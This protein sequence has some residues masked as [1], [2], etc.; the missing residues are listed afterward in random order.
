MS[1]EVLIFGSFVLGWAAASIAGAVVFAAITM[2]ANGILLV[3][4]RHE[5]ARVMRLHSLLAHQLTNLKGLE[6]RLEKVEKHIGV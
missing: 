1:R 5:V 3:G 6:H 2:R 4:F